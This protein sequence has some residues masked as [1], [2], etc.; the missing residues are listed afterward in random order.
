MG[1]TGEV[2]SVLV[3]GGA[4]FIGSALI[5]QLLEETHA[6]I[7]DVDALTYAGNLESLAGARAAWTVQWYLDHPEWVER[8]RSGDYR[9]WMTVHYPDREAG[10]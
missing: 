6:K 3:T 5:R 2:S 7:I 8:V 1:R 9:R 10:A 4:G